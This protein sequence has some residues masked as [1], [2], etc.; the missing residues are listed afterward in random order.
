MDD[1]T[2]PNINLVQSL[3]ECMDSL[4]VTDLNIENSEVLKV[5]KLY[6]NEKTIASSIKTLAFNLKDKWE[7]RAQG[8]ESY[9]EEAKHINSF[10]TLQEE[11]DA[12]R[13]SHL[14]EQRQNATT[15]KESSDNDSGEEQD[16]SR[17]KPKAKSLK[18]QVVPIARQGQI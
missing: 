11:L 12:Y 14:Q 8:M 16:E 6:L 2:Y 9:N 17:D 13:V 10:K 1:G 18:P 7:R 5:I 3:F 15:A 4:N